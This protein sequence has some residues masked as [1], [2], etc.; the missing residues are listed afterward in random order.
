MANA[1]TSMIKSIP[2]PKN[3][4][5]FKL[6]LE[7]HA[8]DIMMVVGTGLIIGSAVYACK[9]T[10]VAKDIL[11]EANEELNK[12]KYGEDVADGDES[13]SE[14]DARNERIKVYSRMT[15][16]LGKCY[17]VSIAGGLAGFSLI[18]GAHK[19]LKDR[20]AMIAAAYAN[21]LASYNSYRAQVKEVLGEEEESILCSGGVREKI[22]IPDENGKI[23]KQ[24]AVVFHDD[25]S[26]HSPYAR[27]FD[28]TCV[29]WSRS[30]SANLTTIRSV[31]A[32][33]NDK[34]RCTGHLF[35]NEVYEALGFPHSTAGAVVGWMWDP[36][37]TV[38]GDNYVDF[39][40][41][42]NAKTSASVRDFINGYEPCI[43]LDFNVDGIIYNL[44]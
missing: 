20:N 15:F 32:W 4:S 31:Q 17:G 19:I 22:D 28:E 5:R 40:I 7:K 2:V 16:D 8:P 36:D 18:F 3:L 1:I 38:H 13:F 30:P 34:L 12:I 29:N 14:K 26:G 23:K 21:L 33:A 37:D 25:G 6:K 24:D 10:I 42:D 11:E 35:L 27:I 39:G 41:F 44:I 9:K 43:W